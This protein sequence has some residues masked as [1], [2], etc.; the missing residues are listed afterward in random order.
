METYELPLSRDYAQRRQD[1]MNLLRSETTAWVATAGSGGPHLVPLLYL[2]DE[3]K[4]TLATA[5]SRPT[6]INLRRQPRVR[7]AVGS[8]Y[9]VVM[10][11]ATTELIPASGIDP[12]TGDAFAALLRRGPD[13]RTV[14]GYVY[15]QAA[16]ER[17]QAWR[18]I[19]ELHGRTLMHDGAWLHPDALPLEGEANRRQSAGEEA[20]DRASAV[21]NSF[22]ELAICCHSL[23]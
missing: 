20:E 15:I 2:W 16:P 10:I 23:M 21:V 11:D 1:T 5:D 7:I 17:I 19:G 4:L 6:V 3:T 22:I 8:P 18:H 13:P 12:A 9:D 14:H